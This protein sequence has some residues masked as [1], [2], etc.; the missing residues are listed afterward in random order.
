MILK[1]LDFE[2]MFVT[3]ERAE[4]GER[5]DALVAWVVAELSS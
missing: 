4:S 1:Y 5:T 2:I 3:Q